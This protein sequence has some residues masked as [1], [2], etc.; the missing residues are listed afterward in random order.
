MRLSET[1][2]AVRCA[3]TRR[4][5]S[6]SLGAAAEY[7]RSRQSQVYLDL[8]PSHGAGKPD[9][10]TQSTKPCAMD[11]PHA[12]QTYAND[13][14]S[15]AAL[16][17]GDK[18]RHAASPPGLR[19]K[20]DT[21][22]HSEPKRRALT[23]APPPK[24]QLDR[25]ARWPISRAFTVRH[26]AC[27]ARRSALEQ[28]PIALHCAPDSAR[29]HTADEQRSY[30]LSPG[31]PL[32]RQSACRTAVKPRFDRTPA[33]MT[34]QRSET[35]ARHTRHTSQSYTLAIA[36]PDTDDPRVVRRVNDGPRARTR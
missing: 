10:R 7:D 29:R 16:L 35:E 20:S 24:R 11:V 15:R 36:R 3:R 34:L 4:L 23:P 13:S 31:R 9:A 30:G 19:P 12:T 2:V 25:L 5:P 8:S 18:P 1:P 22:R 6:L 33:H 21:S 17:G 27:A 26:L 32:M 14:I 28:S